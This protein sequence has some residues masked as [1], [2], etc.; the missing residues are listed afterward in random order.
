MVE[1][2]DRYKQI[3][4]FFNF[5]NTAIYLNMGWKIFWQLES[6]CPE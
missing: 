1:Y 3:V 6:A 2:V 4:L 5:N